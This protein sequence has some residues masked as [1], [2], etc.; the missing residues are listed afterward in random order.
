MNFV[1]FEVNNFDERNRL[2]S[3]L[4]SLDEEKMNQIRLLT[5][6]IDG[7]KDVFGRGNT[8]DFNSFDNANQL[9][10][11]FIYLRYSIK[12]SGVDA[13]R[14]NRLGGILDDF[15]A[16]LSDIYAKRN[17]VN[18]EINKFESEHRSNLS[19]EDLRPSVEYINSINTI[20]NRV[21]ESRNK[22][23]IIAEYIR[24]ID[25]EEFMRNNHRKMIND[26][27]NT[28]NFDLGLICNLLASKN[29]SVDNYRDYRS[30]VKY[31]LANMKGT[32]LV[33]GNLSYDVM[34]YEYDRLVDMLRE[35]K[36]SVEVNN[37][38]EPEVSENQVNHEEPTPS[39]VEEPV[40]PETPVED[41]SLDNNL[42]SDVPEEY[43]PESDFDEEFNVEEEDE[44]LERE[45]VDNSPLTQFKD[46]YK[47]A[48]KGISTAS[49]KLKVNID[50]KVL[51][52]SALRWVGVVGVLAVAA[53]INPALL[54]GGAAIGAGVYE[55]NIAKKMK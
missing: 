24:S 53:V 15:Y 36:R 40:V 9:R 28:I 25:T 48:V 32:S 34:N 33:L 10:E 29:L 21:G 31:N 4:S 23:A 27:E 6:F 45:P 5:L 44:E 41:S 17:D 14:A 18:E 12:Y 20:S 46:E 39:A 2:N 51:R 30:N 13:D 26:L 50:T 37:T 22:I 55:Y 3:E 7:N 54:F 38:P 8:I 16:K 42:E 52:K 35:T 43:I 11:A 1:N 19:D 49:S 47:H